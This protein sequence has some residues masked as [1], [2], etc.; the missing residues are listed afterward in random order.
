MRRK[1]LRSIF[2]VA[3]LAFGLA[4]VAL[5]SYYLWSMRDCPQTAHDCVGWSLL[6]GA[7]FLPP[8]VFIATAGAVTYALRRVSVALIQS[9]LIGVLIA[10]Y[11]LMGFE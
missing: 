2:S 1:L 9:I 7:M 4:L 5:G 11:F 10:Y 8:G 6:G 3:E